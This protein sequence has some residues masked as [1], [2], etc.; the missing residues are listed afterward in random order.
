MNNRRFILLFAALSA[1]IGLLHLLAVK[2][3]LYWT[4]WWFDIPMHI[5]GGLWLS[6]IIFF[7]FVKDRTFF[8]GVSSRL[9]FSFFVV[10]AVSIGVFWE[11]FEVIADATMVSKENYAPDTLSDFLFD[12]V[13]ATIFYFLVKRQLLPKEPNS[14]L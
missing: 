6:A 2:L 1:L 12:A 8:A 11:I 3:W 10:T 13:G 7:F 5:L 9:I 4:L 14:R